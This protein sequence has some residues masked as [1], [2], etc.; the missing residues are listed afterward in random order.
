V[1][2]VNSPLARALRSAGTHVINRFC[3]DVCGLALPELASEHSEMAAYLP[4]CY[5]DR[6][7]VA[8]ARLFLVSA[9]TA[10]EKLCADPP[11]PPGC[12]AEALAQQ[13]LLDSA[14]E[15]LLIEGQDPAPAQALRARLLSDPRLA[16]LFDPALRDLDTDD[17]RRALA[18]AHL[19]VVAWFQPLDDRPVHPYLAHH[20]G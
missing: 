16:P 9:I 4:S 12:A 19:D 20:T 18:D 6:Y 8:F 13:A 3:D 2:V 1:N 14:V 5:A 10:T 17:A 15:Y 11:Q 7:D